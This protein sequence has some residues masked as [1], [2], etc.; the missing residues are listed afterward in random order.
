VPK[1]DEGEIPFRQWERSFLWQHQGSMVDTRTVDQRRRIMQSVGTKNTGPEMAVRRVVHAMGF[2]YALHKCDLPGRPDLVLPARQK[3]I[4]V[5]GCFWHGHDCKKGRP[6]KSRA[7]YWLPKIERNRARDSEVI[8][9]LSLDGWSV[10]TIWQC[11]TRNLVDLKVKL[12]NF[13][14]KSP[15]KRSTRV[16]KS[17]SFAH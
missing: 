17:A 16:R 3:I 7:E 14:S 8:R 4:F 15:N 9:R 12:A 5:H 13:L 11:E 6:P 10:L 1:A 2:R